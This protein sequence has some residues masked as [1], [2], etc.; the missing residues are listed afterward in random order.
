MDGQYFYLKP[1]WGNFIPRDHLVFFDGDPHYIYNSFMRLMKKVEDTKDVPGG[2]FWHN[3][4]HL[5]M[6][7]SEMT[8]VFHK[9]TKDIV[10]FYIIR[11]LKDGKP[12]IIDVFQVFNPGLLRLPSNL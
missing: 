1:K 4:N 6:S 5:L 9:D 2:S 8:I 10:G 3:R 7:F 11:D 12:D